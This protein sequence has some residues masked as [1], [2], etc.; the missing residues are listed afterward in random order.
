MTLTSMPNTYSGDRDLASFQIA[1]GP[2]SPK[3]LDVFR[4]T[5]RVKHYSTRTE[6]TYVARTRSGAVGTMALRCLHIGNLRRCGMEHIEVITE[7]V[8]WIVARLDRL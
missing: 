3:L 4:D 2:P 5:L 6:D 8:V 7:Q 1:E